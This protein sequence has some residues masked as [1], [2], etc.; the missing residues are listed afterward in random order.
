VYKI[1]YKYNLL[2]GDRLIHPIA[3]YPGAKHHS[4]FLGE[5]AFGVEWVSENH[6]V[7]GA[8]IVT[9]QS[10]FDEYGQFEKVLPFEGNQQQL[11]FAV[12]R[13]FSEAGKTYNLITNNCEHHANYVQNGYPESK[14]VRNVF[15]A[16]LGVFALSVL[17]E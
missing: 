7:K 15:F 14:Q 17:A 12:K 13:A 16:L 1:S 8:Q 2:P 10:Y 3:G 4:V 6:K 5:D 11:Q 9:I